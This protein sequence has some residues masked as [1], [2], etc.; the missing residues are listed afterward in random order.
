[1]E[2]VGAQDGGAELLRELEELVRQKRRQLA[3]DSGR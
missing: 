3:K 2:S 1:V